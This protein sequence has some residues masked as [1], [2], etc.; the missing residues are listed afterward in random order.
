M[1][2]LEQVDQTWSKW[3]GQDDGSEVLEALSECLRQLTKRARWALEMRFRDKLP[4]AE[5]AEQLSIT[6]HG[7]KNLMQ[8][9]KKKLRACIDGKMT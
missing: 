8:R 1:A 6:E 3:I 9:A 2:E 7:A 4:R 5:I